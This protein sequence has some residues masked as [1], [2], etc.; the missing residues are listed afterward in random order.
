VEVKIKMKKSRVRKTNL[1]D[2]KRIIEIYS[3]GKLT[4][5][6]IGK[7][8]SISESRVSQIV[9]DYYGEKYD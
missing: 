4:M 5:K 2:R 7:L 1:K 6:E 3:D 8:F 9:S